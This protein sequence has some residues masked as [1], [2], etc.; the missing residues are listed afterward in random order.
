MQEA[1]VLREEARAIHESPHGRD[2]L[3]RCGQLHRQALHGCT[4]AIELLRVACHVLIAS[5][6]DGMAA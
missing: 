3:H 4:E 5:K 1:R 6:A 2:Q